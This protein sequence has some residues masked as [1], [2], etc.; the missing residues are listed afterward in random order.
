MLTIT[1]A[2]AEIKLIDNKITA[3]ETFVLGNLY[4]AKHLPDPLADTK[5]KVEAEV[6]AT[7]D[8]RRRRVKIR[9]AIAEAN[10]KT[11]ITIKASTLTIF[12][13][14]TWRREVSEKEKTFLRSIHVNIKRGIDSVTTAP[15]FYKDAESQENK[16]VELLPSLDYSVF[17]NAEAEVQEMLDKLDGLLSLKNATVT[18]DV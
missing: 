16:I 13:W 17:A 6:Q 5:A 2:L 7:M 14:L 1:E 12:E 3:K 11:E 15:K 10:I 9:K 8:L 4:R 18:I